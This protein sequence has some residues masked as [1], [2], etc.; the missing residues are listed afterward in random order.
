MLVATDTI[1]GVKAVT[2]QDNDIR[3]LS[4][5]GMETHMIFNLGMDLPGFASFPLLETEQGRALLRK[6]YRDQIAV[7]Q[8]TGC[9]AC[10]ESVTWMANADRAAALGYD[11][12]DLKRIN[13]EAIEFLKKLETEIPVCISAQIG[14]RGDGYEAAAMTIDAAQAYHAPQIA[15]LAKA[16]CDMISAFTIGTVDEAIGMVRA[17]AVVGV[18]ISIALTVETDGRLP[19][20]TILSDAIS[21]IDAA[22]SDGVSGYLVNCAHPDHLVLEEAGARLSGLV[23]NA[24]RLSHAEL[25]EAEELDDGNPDELGRQMGDLARKYPK[26]RVFGGCCGTDMRHLRAIGRGVHG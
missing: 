17:A 15:V 11:A 22:T 3:W 9:G 2:A 18:P 12:G 1:Q 19:D 21:R 24:S 20:G 8:E 14:P 7:A 23:V 10:L 13:R 6:L 16:G 25:D 26:M 5:T 4:W